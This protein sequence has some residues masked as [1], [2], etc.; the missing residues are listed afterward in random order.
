L[1]TLAGEE[2]LPAKVNLTLPAGSRLAI[3]TPG[4]GGWGRGEAGLAL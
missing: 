3:R 1:L 2:P 4:G